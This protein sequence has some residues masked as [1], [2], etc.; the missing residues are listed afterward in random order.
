[1]TRLKAGYGLVLRS[2]ESLGS[3]NNNLQSRRDLAVFLTGWLKYRPP[4]EI[5]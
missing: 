4:A 3:E 2:T 1:M 5:S